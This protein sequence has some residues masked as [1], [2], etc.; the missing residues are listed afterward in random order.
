MRQTY[1]I[2]RVVALCLA[3]AV[4]AFCLVTNSTRHFVNL[5]ASALTAIDQHPPF[6][7]SVTHGKVVA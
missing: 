4:E 2:V 6:S 5:N 3:E 7:D 1:C